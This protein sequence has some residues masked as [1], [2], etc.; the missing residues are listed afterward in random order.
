M[1]R[2]ARALWTVA[3][4]ARTWLSLLALTLLISGENLL[5]FPP[6]VVYMRRVTGGMTFLDFGFEPATQAHALLVAFGPA[7]RQTQALLTCTVDMLVPLASAIFG[8]L[9]IT[10][11]GRR[12]F[13]APGR[14]L[15]AAGLP[16]LAALCDYAENATISLLLVTFPHDPVWLSRVTHFLTIAKVATYSLTLALVLLAA[17]WTLGARFAGTRAS[18]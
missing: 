3:T 9:A 11:L 15:G 2:A 14:W 12:I 16:A 18:K 17:A 4:P 8:A 6:G 13:G 7:G 1:S 10:S 5:P